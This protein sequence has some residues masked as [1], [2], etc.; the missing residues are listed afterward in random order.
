MMSFFKKVRGKKGCLSLSTYYLEDGRDSTVIVAAV[1]RTRPRA[2]PLAMITTRKSMYGFPLVS[3]MGMGL[4]L[5]ALWAAGADLL[6][7]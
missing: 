6:H 2:V 5:V 7:V 1:M 3:Y 4:R